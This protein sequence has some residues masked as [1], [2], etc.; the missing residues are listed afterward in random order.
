MSQERILD[1][2]F[3]SGAVRFNDQNNKKTDRIKACYLRPVNGN[4]K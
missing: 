3:L 1:D 4:Q 2:E